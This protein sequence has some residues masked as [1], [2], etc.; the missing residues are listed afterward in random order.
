M[1]DRV[2]VANRGEIAVRIM[3]TLSRMGISSVAVYSDADAGALHVGHADEA[4]RIGR[5]PA[6]ESYLDIERVIAAALAS[7]AQAVH[8]G[9]GFL[10]ENPTFARACEDAGLV[11][12][13]PRPDVIA[14]MGDKIAAKQIAIAAGVPV[15]PGRHQPDMDDAALSAAIAEIGYPALLKPA[16]GGGGKGMRVVREPQEIAAAIAGARRESRAGFGDDRLLV[17]R[18]VDRPRHIEVQVLGDARGHVVHLGERDCTLQ[19]RHQ[20]VIEEAPSVLLDDDV[21]ADL[22][23]AAVRLARSVSYTNAGTV[24]FVVPVHSPQDFAFLEMN[25]RLQVE[26]PVTEAVTGIDLVE[27]QIRIAAGEPLGLRQEDITVTGH[28]VE[29]RIYAEDP[30][31]DYLPSGGTVL[32]WDA[33]GGVRVDAGVLRGSAVTADYDPMIAKVI[34]HAPTRSEALAALGRALRATTCLGVTTNIDDLA[35]LLEDDRVMTGDMD[36]SLLDSR[37]P[38]VSTA[39]SSAVA[40]A[41]TALLPAPGGDAWS[42]GDAWRFGGPAAQRW[43]VGEHRVAVTRHPDR[44]EV[45]VD[46]A[47]V[48]PSPVIASAF[49]GS[50]LFF[51]DAEGHHS[52]PA[53]R[54]RDRR[55]RRRAENDPSGTWVA[56]SPMPG[57]VIA[58]EVSV[59]DAVDAGVP[60]VVVEAMKMEHTLRSPGRG[61]I[62]H[63]HVSPGTQVRLDAALIEVELVVTG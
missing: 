12:I 29:A 9:Y 58:V 24:E 10:S 56:R 13:G 22:C 14:A 38:R 62:T 49:D 50:R 40:A 15:V 19:R 20:K 51:R 17:E 21:R 30:H 4:V 1:F 41:A 3:R 5:A 16:A 55:G 23:E 6:R 33:P 63:V 39:E 45:E 46:G 7:N 34:A 25:T 59:G 11:F 47:V 36:T 54:P 8:P 52:L 37:V 26:H 53:R 43:D 28:A 35:D 27:R 44:C 32:L 2:L 57:S 48:D 42:A 60:L 61:T 31:R 18:Y